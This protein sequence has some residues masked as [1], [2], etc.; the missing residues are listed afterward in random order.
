MINLL[1][2]MIQRHIAEEMAKTSEEAI[3]KAIQALLSEEDE[4]IQNIH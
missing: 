2:R 4:E 1:D 3:A